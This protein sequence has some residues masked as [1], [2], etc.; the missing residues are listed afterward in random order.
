VTWDGGTFSVELTARTVQDATTSR[1]LALFGRTLT[2]SFRYP[3]NPPPADQEL[4]IPSPELQL[5]WATL[6][7]DPRVLLLYWTSDRSLTFGGISMRG[8]NVDGAVVAIANVNN[9]AFT[10]TLAHE[11]TTWPA[12][13]RLWNAGAA[14]LDG[15][16]ATRWYFYSAAIQRWIHFM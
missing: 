12:S 3:V 14:N 8:G 6:G 4:P 5:L 7:I 15:V 16:Q 1:A 13:H 11:D 10:L 2:E 9:N